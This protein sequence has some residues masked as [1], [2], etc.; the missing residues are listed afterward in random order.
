MRPG[1]L[2]ALLLQVHR[3]Q[4]S[5]FAVQLMTNSDSTKFWFVQS[6]VFAAVWDVHASKLTVSWMF[7]G[8]TR[9]HQQERR[10]FT[11]CLPLRSW[12]FMA[13]V[14]STTMDRGAWW[15][16]VLLWNRIRRLNSAIRIELNVI[17][18]SGALNITSLRTTIFPQWNRNSVYLSCLLLGLLAFPNPFQRPVGLKA[19][20]DPFACAHGMQS[21]CHVQLFLLAVPVL[22]ISAGVSSVQP[23]HLLLQSSQKPVKESR[24][25]LHLTIL[26]IHFHLPSLLPWIQQRNPWLKS[27][28]GWQRK[29]TF[30][31]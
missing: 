7:D 3:G 1:I 13:I 11:R 26:T 16:R 5:Q 22:G 8:N 30:K 2:I 12:N 21:H 27:N 4:P 20:C 28:V 17:L 23:R 14:R 19:P 10:R 31:S 29:T 9:H 24:M 15:P 6:S 18:S 25:S